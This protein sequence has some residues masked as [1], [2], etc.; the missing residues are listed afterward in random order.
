MEGQEQQRQKLDHMPA[1]SKDR[2]SKVSALYLHGT[3]TYDVFL[4]VVIKLN[5][6]I[7]MGCALN[8]STRLR[9]FLNQ[10]FMFLVCYILLIIMEPN[11]MLRFALVCNNTLVR[12]ILCCHFSFYLDLSM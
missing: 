5:Y 10:A 9:D 4:I 11:K 6:Q 2:G 12:T 1:G 3:Y 7:I 8:Q